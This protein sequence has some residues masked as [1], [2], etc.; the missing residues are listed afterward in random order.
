MIA[1]C[2][3]VLLCNRDGSVVAAAHAGWRGLSSGV[4]ENTVDAMKVDPATLLAY[5][6]PAIG[7][8]A[9]EVGERVHPHAEMLIKTLRDLGVAVALVSGDRRERVLPVA[10]QSDVCLFI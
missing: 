8:A 6:G 2:M 4:L 10:Q 9:F 5:L 7:P 1:D 3:P